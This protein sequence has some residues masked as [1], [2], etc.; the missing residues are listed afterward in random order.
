[1]SD[2]DN[3]ETSDIPV[4]EDTEQEEKKELTEEEKE[5]ET[6]NKLLFINQSYFVYSVMTLVKLLKEVSNKL[7]DD[8]SIPENKKI[9]HEK[10]R[11]T[12]DNIIA[13]YQSSTS[14]DDSSVDHVKIIKKV[15]Y[16]LKDNIELIKNKD[17]ALFT[18]RNSEKK[19]TTIIPGLNINLIYSYLTEEQQKE[20]WTQ[21]YTMFVSTV[22][23]VYANTSKSR[24]KKNVL[25]TVEYCK[26]ELAKSSNP[27]LNVF[28]G[29]GN[30][31]SGLDLEALMN[32]DIMIPGT[33]ANTGLLG[34]LGVDKLMNLENLSDEIKNFTEN[35]VN[36]TIDTLGGLLGND[37]DVKDVCST[38][39]KTVI[40][41]LKQNGIEN[42]FDV[43]KRVSSQ[44]SGLIDP[45]KMA[46]TANKMTD[47]MASNSDK[48]KDLKDD[49]GNPIGEQLFNQ[50]KQTMDMANKLNK[51]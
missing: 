22:T 4:N 49:N 45:N 41:D 20:V 32:K 12:C 43:A 34:S 48:I 42:I 23:M 9:V 47:L 31:E 18:V 25:D 39:V 15:F 50:F 36:E 21:I 28:M 13:E 3:I 1:M 26:K 6:N 11:Q 33:E 27:M 44:L 14:L 37:S 35:D 51:K 2:L 17:A 19:I 40:S 38:M 8:N 30:S 29:I 24:H 16:V 7:V 10:F 46:K 5:K